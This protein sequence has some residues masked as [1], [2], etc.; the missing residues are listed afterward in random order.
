MTVAALLA[1][2]ATVPAD[3]QAKPAHGRREQNGGRVPRA[4]LLHLAYKPVHRDSAGWCG[5]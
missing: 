3:V 1:L 4:P 2:G 5:W